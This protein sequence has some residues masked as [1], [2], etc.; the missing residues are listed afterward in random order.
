MILCLTVV[1][2]SIRRKTS[3]VKKNHLPLPSESLPVFAAGLRAGKGWAMMDPGS[4]DGPG[5]GPGTGAA[6]GMRKEDG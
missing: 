3:A 4:C 1:D 6:Q 2:V 5:A